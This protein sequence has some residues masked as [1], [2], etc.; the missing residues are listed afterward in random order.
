M[1]QTDTASVRPRGLRWR[2]ADVSLRFKLYV[3]L[4]VSILGLLVIAGV[5][6]S[7]SVVNQRLVD[8]TLM[9]QRQLSD[10]A[11]AINNDLLTVQNQAFEFYDTWDS[12]GFENR[13]QGGFARAREV[14]VTPLQEQIDQIRDNVIAIEQLEPDEHTRTILARITSSMDAYETSLLEMSDHMENMG[15]YYS[16]EAGQ[17]R[18][19]MGELQALLDDADMGSLKAAALEIRRQEKNFF[20]YSDFASARIV[21]ELIGQF[22]EQIAAVDDDQLSPEEK[23]R[24][25]Y[26]LEDYHDRFLAAANYF[27]LLDQSR[28]NLISQSDLTGVLV[29]GLFERQQVEFDATLEQ[30][31]GRQSDITFAVIGLALI[32][33]FVSVSVAYIVADQIVRPVQMLGE[34]AGRLGAGDL[35]VRAP[36]RSRDEIGAT[37]VAFNLMADRLR[38]S[39]TGLEQRVADRTRELEQRSVYLEAAAE[40]GRAA[41]SIL[42]TDRLIRQV[43]DLIRNRFGFYYVGLFLVEGAGEWAVLRAGTGEFGQMMLAREHR[44]AVGGDSMIG[45]CVSRDEA[46]IALDVGEEAARFDNPLLPDTRS[47]LALPLRSRGRVVGA[48][49]V[50]SVEEAAFDAASI[51]GLQTM[52]DQVAVALDNARLFADAQAALETARSAYSEMSREAWGKLLRAQ[53]DMAYRSDERGVSSARD[54]WRPEME[55]ALRE[56]GAVQGDVT[57][58]GEFPLAIPIKVRGDVIGVLDTHKPGGADAWLPKEIALLETLAEQLGVALEGARLYDDA[59]RRATRERLVSEITDRMRRAT[60]VE[61]IVQAAVDELFSVLGTSRVFVQLESPQGAEMMGRGDEVAV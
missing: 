29:A 16:G 35:N 28:G 11:S 17:M 12:T 48:M 22:G 1:N 25:D 46:R 30:L 59:Q 56:G 32:A 50:Q 43:V 41:T 14:Y 3:A 18:E 51:A 39:L 38:E 27:R 57:A 47:E 2:L 53:P 45:Q 23:A 6:V 20:L 33:F 54:V 44:L 49:S 31:R 42:E 36:V 8:R 21:Q 19:V 10:L 55:R 5:T 13:D 9:R 61:G 40:V 34:A 7:I 15:F 26:L 4:G 24:L 58:G 52:A 37:A 60:D